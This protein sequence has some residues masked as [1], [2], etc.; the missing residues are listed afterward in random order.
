ML[1]LP[2]L[3]KIPND[4]ISK[5]QEMFKNAQNYEQEKVTNNIEIMREDYRRV[6]KKFNTFL[7]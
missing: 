1:N 6:I 2:E 4:A 7:S 5:V 3:V